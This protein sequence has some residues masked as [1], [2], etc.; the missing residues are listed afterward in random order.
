MY[1]TDSA[2]MHAKAKMLLIAA[3]TKQHAGAQGE[4]VSLCN[5]I[6]NAV[7]ALKRRGPLGASVE[8]DLGKRS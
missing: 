2:S 8:S 6:Q 1:A 4:K 5:A 3:K 7:G